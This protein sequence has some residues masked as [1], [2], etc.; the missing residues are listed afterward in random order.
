ML[1]NYSVFR[2]VMLEATLVIESSRRQDFRRPVRAL[3]FPV[4]EPQVRFLMT[5][6]I[7]VILDNSFACSR[8]CSAG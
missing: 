5:G 3:K 8:K 6:I 7:S 4:E 1:G 2:F